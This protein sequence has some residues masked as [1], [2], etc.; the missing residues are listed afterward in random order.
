MERMIARFD[1][2]RRRLQQLLLH[3]E[4]SVH[5]R[6]GIFFAILI[7]VFGLM[8]LL[9]VHTP[10][11]IDDY[12]FIISWKT[13]K[14]VS[15]LFDVIASQTVYYRLW[16][17]RIILLGLTQFFLWLGKPVFNVANSVAY[18]LLLLEVYALA[19]PRDRR[20]CWP[21]LL[22]SHFAL[23]LCIPFFGTV[24][25]WLT[26]ACNYLWG[27][28]LSLLPLIILRSAREDG[29]FSC[30]G[31]WGILAIAVGFI[32]GWTN[33]NMAGAVFL[34][35]A[36]SLIWRKLRREQPAAWL[37]GMLA[38]QAAGIFVMLVAPGNY[39]RASMYEWSSLL[40]EL[41][42]RAIVS[43]VYGAIYLGVPLIAALMLWALI[44]ALQLPAAR[45]GGAALYLFCAVMGALAM[46]VSPVISDRSFTG[47]F[48]LALAG[49]LMLLSDLDAGTRAFDTAKLVALPL[50]VL[51]GIYSGYGAFKDV[52]DHEAQWLQRVQIIEDAAQT[53]QGEAVISSVPSHSRFTMDITIEQEPSQWPNS[54]IS[55]VLGVSVRGE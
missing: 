35:V 8:L 29:V 16:G 39:A 21:V 3:A 24:F 52:R 14:P 20:F 54:S 19:R 9:N 32:A 10:V 11:Q 7:G 36:A 41:A 49:A 28:A 5:V 42:R 50:I 4:E 40:L 37:W 27:T 18:I 23:F 51:L 48:V 30:G 47:P 26:G 2:V 44:N 1:A 22:A 12:D 15:G 6:A 31:L 38:A 43:T 46:I 13:G 17:G 33:E 45:R 55:A 53:G 25:L 34:L